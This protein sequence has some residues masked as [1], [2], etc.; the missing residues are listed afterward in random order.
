MK[1]KKKEI[2]ATE[3]TTNCYSFSNTPR[4]RNQCSIRCSDMMVQNSMTSAMT[5]FLTTLTQAQVQPIN[6]HL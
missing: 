4:R 5:V 2:W 1:E 3:V 6:V